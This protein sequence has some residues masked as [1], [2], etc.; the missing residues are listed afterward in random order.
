MKCKETC[1]QLKE[2]RR[3]IAAAN[4][5]AYVVDECSYRG[6]CLGT[7]PKCEAEVRYLE[8]QLRQRQMLGKAVV[9]AGLSLGVLTANA[10]N[11]SALVVDDPVKV[12]NTVNTDEPYNATKGKYKITGTVLYADSELGNEPCVGAKMFFKKDYRKSNEKCFSIADTDGNFVIFTDEL[13]QSLYFT[14]VGCEVVEVKI[15]KDN[16]TTPVNVVLKDVEQILMG[17]VVEAK[18][19]CWRPKFLRKKSK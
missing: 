11:T 18:T 17:E 12:V 6:R 9:V 8:S 15:T 14:F 4:D 1:R 13:P 19:K 10:G 7:C 16:Y 2:I 3:Q 5:I